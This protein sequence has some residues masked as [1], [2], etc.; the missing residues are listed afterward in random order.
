M[1]TYSDESPDASIGDRLASSVKKIAQGIVGKPS[2]GTPPMGAANSSN[3]E[4][5]SEAGVDHASTP[6]NTGAS[7][8]STDSWNKY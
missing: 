1:G 6:S 4:A 2:T 8:Q 7:A 5:A 3:S